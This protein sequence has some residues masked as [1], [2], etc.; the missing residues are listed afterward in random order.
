MHSYSDIEKPDIEQLIN[1][2]VKSVHKIAW[3]LFGRVK[4]IVDIEDLI[5]IGMV[6]LI[7][8][9]QNFKPQ[10]G[11]DF[12]HYANIRIKGEIIDFLRKNSI[13]CRTT[14]K[15]KQEAEIKIDLFSV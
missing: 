5:Q 9:A 11:V 13:L 1:S 3:H 4:S 7:T 6:G 15:R 2:Q 10:P 12:Q 8:A 14:I